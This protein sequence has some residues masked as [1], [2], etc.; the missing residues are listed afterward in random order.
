MSSTIGNVSLYQ[1]F[2]GEQVPKRATLVA[3]LLTSQ[4][5]S[6]FVAGRS[7]MNTFLALSALTFLV[8]VIAEGPLIRLALQRF[9]RRSDCVRTQSIEVL[10]THFDCLRDDQFTRLVQNKRV[11]LTGGADQ[12]VADIAKDLLRHR[13]AAVLLVDDDNEK[14]EQHLRYLRGLSGYVHAQVVRGSLADRGWVKSE[15]PKL[16]ADIVFDVTLYRF[17]KTRMDNWNFVDNPDFVRLAVKRYERAEAAANLV[18]FCV[19]GAFESVCF[20]LPHSRRS[21]VRENWASVYGELLRGKVRE[22]GAH[23][24]DSKAVVSVWEPLDSHSS[25]PQ[26]V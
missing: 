18:D 17:V 23:I 2:F 13:P 10:G 25:V 12:V 3:A 20:A 9:R 14:L 5:L 8:A 24:A 1:F 21:N 16:H 26:A 15:L 6:L 11:A 7:S 19:S 4:A 22:I